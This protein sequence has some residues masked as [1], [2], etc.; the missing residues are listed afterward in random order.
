MSYLIIFILGYIFGRYFV[1][2]LDYLIEWFSTF[3][4][5]RTS[6]L[7]YKVQEMFPEEQ[8]RITQDSTDRIGFVVPE[9]YWDEFEDNGVL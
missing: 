8:D 6:K 5:Y 3:V 4:S 1:V 7:A 2:L 9:D